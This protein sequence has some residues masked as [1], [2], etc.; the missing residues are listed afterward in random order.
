M[1]SPVYDFNMNFPKIQIIDDKNDNFHKTFILDP[2][3]RGFGLTIGNA[4]RRISLSSLPGGAVKSFSI[5]GVKHEYDVIENAIEDVTSVILPLKELKL[6][7]SEQDKEFKLTIDVNK[8]GEIKAEDFE[9]PAEVEIINPDLK[10]LTLSEKT[11]FSMEV[12]VLKGR[13]Y[14]LADENRGKEKKSGIIFVDSIF[15]PV[16]KFAYHVEDTRVG[17]KTNFDKLIV[18]IWTNGMLKP[19]E[20]ISYSAHILKE[21]A[22]LIE[23]LENTIK[24]SEIF[25]TNI[26]GEFNVIEEQEPSEEKISIE[27]LDISNRAYNGLKRANINTIEELTQKTKKEIGTLDNIGLKTVEEIESQ[28]HDLGFSFKDE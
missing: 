26:S 11:D 12:I 13:G 25:N 3:E 14:V 16:T 27:A 9:I 7:I 21:H 28:L 17:D 1:P 5:K 2:L 4:L 20:I 24:I 15:T 22:Q 18:D 10:I 23:D 8:K 6:K 19:E